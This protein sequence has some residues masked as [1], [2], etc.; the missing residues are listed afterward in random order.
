MMPEWPPDGAPDCSRPT[1]RVGRGITA[2]DAWRGLGADPEY[3]PR[4]HDSPASGRILWKLNRA[5]ML[6]LLPPF[7]S[8]GDGAE[9]VHA[10]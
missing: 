8:C 4:R 1:A 7:P 5:G 6:A 9:E 2:A 10:A 3:E